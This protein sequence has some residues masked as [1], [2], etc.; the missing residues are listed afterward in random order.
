MFSTEPSTCSPYIYGWRAHGYDL[1]YVV[2]TVVIITL[3]VLMFAIFSA[4]LYF[5][6]YTIISFKRL[7]K[8]ES[9]NQQ[10]A[11]VS[12]EFPKVSVI[13]PARNEER[14][15][16]K[17]LDSLLKQSYPNFEIVAINDSSFDKTGEIIQRYHI[18]NPKVVAINAGPKPDEVWIGK[19]WACY[20]GYLNSTGE[21]FLFTDA[22]TVHSTSMMSLAITYMTKQSLHALTAIPRILLEENIWIKITLPLLWTLSYAKYSA[23][24]ANNPKSK[25]G[26]F[27]GSFFI[28]TRKTYEAVGTHKAVKSEIVEDG[29]LGRKVKEEKFNLRVVR[30]ERYVEAVWATDFNTLWHGL[31]RLMIPLYQR[32]R[33]NALLMTVSSFLLLLLPFI[34]LPFLLFSTATTILSINGYSS[35]QNFLLLIDITTIALLFSTSAIQSKYTLFQNTLYTVGSPLA[36]VIIFFSFMS[37][38]LD[39]TKKN[40]VNWKDRLYTIKESH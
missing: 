30:G 28:I 36:G 24:R 20:Q 27:F 34:L 26:Y 21:I 14:Y 33:A 1:S 3:T 19:N 31:R 10:H 29:A 6:I 13:L 15:I 23:L 5:L 35:I 11:V 12:D 22:D 7:P 4:W 16:A 40:A 32:E 37:S 8:L 9:M 38:I 2:G 39:A 25:I 17:C 18:I